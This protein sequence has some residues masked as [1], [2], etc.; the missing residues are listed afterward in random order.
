MKILSEV[1]Q[2]TVAER[3]MPVAG[4]GTF[5]EGAQAVYRRGEARI[6]PPVPWQLPMR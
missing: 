5:A 4:K 3:E 1:R 6:L 2:N